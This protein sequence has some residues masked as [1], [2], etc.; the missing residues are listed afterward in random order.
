MDAVFRIEAGIY[1]SL[2]EDRNRSMGLSALPQE[3]SIHPRVF[4]EYVFS[5]AD[6]NLDCISEYNLY[7]FH[8]TGDGRGIEMMFSCILHQLLRTDLATHCSGLDTNCH[9]GI[10]GMGE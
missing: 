6:W 7:L 3:K 10:Q 4:G 5:D 2:S 9:T 8:N 1:L